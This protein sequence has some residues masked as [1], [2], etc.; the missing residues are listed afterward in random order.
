MT[1]EI[2]GFISIAVLLIGLFAWL[3]QDMSRMRTELRGDIANLDN[4][5]SGDIVKLNER[6]DGLENKVDAI[7]D[8]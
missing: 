1:I 4:K 7:D 2:G 3:R 5:L 6:M 8:K